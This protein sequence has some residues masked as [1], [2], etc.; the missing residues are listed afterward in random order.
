MAKTS[1]YARHMVRDTRTSISSMDLSTSICEVFSHVSALRSLEEL[2]SPI[3]LVRN[4]VNWTVDDV[5]VRR[6]DVPDEALDRVLRIH[7]TLTGFL[8]IRSAFF[9]YVPCQVDGKLGTF[10][11]EV[12][13]LQGNGQRLLR[14]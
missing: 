8:C 13:G 7:R 12:G 6:F 9:F 2:I 14:I 11:D 10:T 5:G 4:V 1:G 3:V